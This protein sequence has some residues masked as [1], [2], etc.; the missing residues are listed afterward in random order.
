MG[1]E[2]SSIR[3]LWNRC[4]R[5]ARA[6]DQPPQTSTVLELAGRWMRANGPGQQARLAGSM[7]RRLL[8]STPTAP[9]RRM[10]DIVA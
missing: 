3:S 2:V 7:G 9:G 10:R 8:G 1:T 4:D 5:G 6:A